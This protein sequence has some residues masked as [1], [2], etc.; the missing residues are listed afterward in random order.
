MIMIVIVM[1]T[2]IVI[3]IVVVIVTVTVTV[4]MTVVV[5]RVDVFGDSGTFLSPAYPARYPNNQNQ[6]YTAHLTTPGLKTVF[7][8]LDVDLQAHQFLS[9]TCVDYVQIQQTKYCGTGQ[10]TYSITVEGTELQMYFYS[11]SS[12]NGKAF[13]ITYVVV[14]GKRSSFNRHL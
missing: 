1:V 10:G 14:E 9:N 5:I 7:L 8:H 3:V 2:V 11:D 12:K 4:V 6:N 13:N